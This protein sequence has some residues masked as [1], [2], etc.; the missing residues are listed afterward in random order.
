MFKRTE[1]RTFDD[2]GLC[3]RRSDGDGVLSVALN[4]ERVYFIHLPC[5][6]A[7]TQQSRKG[8]MGIHV[9]FIEQS[10][11]SPYRHH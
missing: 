4:S 9:L 10:P 6:G 2:D 3:R 8:L 11:P 1:S 5:N 7:E